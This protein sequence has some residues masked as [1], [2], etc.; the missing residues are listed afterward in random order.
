MIENGRYV[1]CMHC[2]ELIDLDDPSSFKDALSR[3][4]FGISGFCQKC[5]DDTFGG[6]LEELYDYDEDFLIEDEDG[7]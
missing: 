1:P 7:K 5:Q 3:K 2:L 4:E 6:G